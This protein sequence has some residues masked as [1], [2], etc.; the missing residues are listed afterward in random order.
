MGEQRVTRRHSC[1]QK[2][3]DNVKESFKPYKSP[4]KR[5]IFA[6]FLQHAASLILFFFLSGHRTKAYS[7]LKHPIKGKNHLLIASYGA[8]EGK[9]KKLS[10]RRKVTGWMPGANWERELGGGFLQ[11][12][13]IVEIDEQLS[14]VLV[15]VFSGP[16]IRSF[17]QQSQGRQTRLGVC[18]VKTDWQLHTAYS[19]VSWSKSPPLPGLKK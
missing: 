19:I 9:K 4:S 2:W 8:A 10:Q 18:L 1:H 11:Q 6:H 16:Q 5:I 13:S 3:A 7:S 17:V 15:A 14:D 12:R